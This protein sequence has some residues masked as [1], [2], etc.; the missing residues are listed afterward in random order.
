MIQAPIEASDPHSR[1]SL[2][3]GKAF[4]TVDLLVPSSSDQLPW[5]FETLISFDK[6]SYL[7]QEVNCTDLSP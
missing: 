7:Y 6:T 2:L 4:S 1:E 5:I 3:K